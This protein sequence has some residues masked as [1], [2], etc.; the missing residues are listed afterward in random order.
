MPTRTS[1]SRRVNRDERVKSVNRNRGYI[2]HVYE[3]TIKCSPPVVP[4]SS[5]TKC[6]FLS[7]SPLPT[8]LFV[9]QYIL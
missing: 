8:I 2:D 5:R 3:S 6:Q 7:L 4:L 1:S 9:A